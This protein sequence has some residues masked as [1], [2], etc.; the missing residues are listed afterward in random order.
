MTSFQSNILLIPIPGSRV[1]TLCATPVSS[2][3][4]ATHLL[5][6][7]HSFLATHPPYPLPSY[8]PPSILHTFSTP[9]CES[10]SKLGYRCANSTISGGFSH[11]ICVVC[12]LN[13]SFDSGLSLISKFENRC[14]SMSFVSTRA[15]LCGLLA[16]LHK[17]SR[18][19]IIYPEAIHALG[20]NE[21]GAHAPLLSSSNSSSPHH[22]SGQ[23][24]SAL[25]QFSSERNVA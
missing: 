25:L 3:K 5:P 10:G 11:A 17:G 23:N 7:S 1:G 16:G 12:P 19:D 24:S 14:V 18:I 6:W 20:P 2:S 13:Q 15:R 21:N 22:L 9:L 4:L 8:P